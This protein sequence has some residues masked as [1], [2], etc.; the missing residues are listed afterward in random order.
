M[1]FNLLFLFLFL[2]AIHL[3]AGTAVPL[4][5]EVG[6]TVGALLVAKLF[7]GGSNGGIPPS[8]YQQQDAMEMA[9][10]IEE[11]RKLAQ[12]LKDHGP[13]SEE[14]QALKEKAA[15]NERRA[16][17][18]R[19][20][21]RKRIE[22]EKARLKALGMDHV[23]NINIAFTGE[24][25]VGK[26]SMINSL[27]GL[28]D[29]DK[30]AAPSSTGVIGTIASASYSFSPAVDYVKLWDLPGGSVS[31]YPAATYY[32]DRCLDLFDAVLLFDTE[33][34]H[35]LTLNIL[36]KAKRDGI[37]DKFVLIYTKTD[38]SM[39]AVLRNSKDLDKSSA[40]RSLKDT[41]TKSWREELRKVLGDDANK[42][43]ILFTSAWELI[44]NKAPVYD[45]GTLFHFIIRAAGKRFPEGGIEQYY[46]DHFGGIKLN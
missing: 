5:A 38:V 37:L 30:G 14:Y 7:A 29:T 44:D 12:Q 39:N 17:E 40:L 23:N 13:E 24:S 36:Q 41:V 10:L 15:E 35:E 3:S 32:E 9:S 2:A 21:Q 26:S 27:R 46:I 45:E 33:R 42:V 1:C 6:K 25:G 28:R 11:N 43:G 19:E 4:F 31:G 34:P 20:K 18:E 8:M 16:T 22:E